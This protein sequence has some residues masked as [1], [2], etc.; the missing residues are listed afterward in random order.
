MLRLRQTQTPAEGSNQQ[1]APGTS[2]SDVSDTIYDSAGRVV[3]VNN[4]YFISN[5]PS[6]TLR[7]P[8][9][10]EASI[11][12]STQTGYDGAG[13][14]TTDRLIGFGT[15]KWATNYAYGGDH[16]DVTPPAGGTLTRTYSDARGRT[17]SLIQYHAGT[18]SGAADTTSY[19]YDPAGNRLS[20]T[21]QAG[22]QWH[23]TYDLFGDALS[24]TDPDTGATT[25]TYDAGQR[26][27]QTQDARGAKLQYGY[28]QLNRKISLQ[29]YQ[30]AGSG[31]WATD[32]VWTY[33]TLAKGQLTS[34][35][36]YVGST[37]TTLGTAYSESVTG[38][39]LMYRPTATSYTLP[40]AAAPLAGTYT[41]SY[42]YNPDGSLA[43]Q[44]DPAEGG[45]PAETISAGYTAIGNPAGATIP[46]NQFAIKYSA[47]GQVSQ[48]VRSDGAKLLWDTYGYDL[49]SARLTADIVTNT[50]GVNFA[51][52]TYAYNNAGS[53]TSITDT[54]TTGAVDTQCFSY[55]Y[56]QRLTQAD[57]PANNNCATAP[58]NTNLGGPAPYWQ[59][60]TYD[61]SGDRQTVIRHAT[62][63]TGSDLR[64]T[65]AYPALGS[66]HR[67]QT[68]TH[69]S[70]PAGTTSYTNTGTA[71]YGY[72][73]AGNTTTSPGQTLSYDPRGDL[74]SVTTSAGTQTNVYD[75]DGELLLRTDPTNGTTAYLG[76]TELTA[77]PGGAV[78]ANRTYQ[79]AGIAYACRTT[80]TG[81]G[82]PTLTWLSAD[83]QGT[84]TIAVDLTTAAA[85]VR[86]NDPFGNPR[87]GSAPAW[88]NTDG[89]LN[90]PTNAFTATT[91]LGA[92]EY[93]PKIGRFL[94]V[95][96][97]LD[98]GD[99]QS[100]NGY[101]YA[102]NDPVNGSD[103]DGLCVKIDSASAPCL[104]STQ[105]AYPTYT[106]NQSSG[107]HNARH[108]AVGGQG[109]GSSCVGSP[110][111]YSKP[112][113]VKQAAHWD[114]GAADRPHRPKVS[115][116]AS[117][118][119]VC[120][121]LVRQAQKG[122][123]Y[124]FNRGDLANASAYTRNATTAVN[125]SYNDQQRAA[126][127][128]ASGV[129]PYGL[130]VVAAVVGVGGGFACVVAEP[131]VEAAPNVVRGGI[132]VGRAIKGVI[133]RGSNK[134]DAKLGK[135][136]VRENTDVVGQQVHVPPTGIWSTLLTT[137]VQVMTRWD[138]VVQ[139]LRRF[140]R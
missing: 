100:L 126:A 27:T 74:G 129:C 9:G 131:C 8:T 125:A 130:C 89:Y 106:N 30:S 65:Y 54:P 96:P 94:S 110:V 140:F 58:T 108:K 56:A 124:Y 102:D 3:T 18:F 112:I 21:D 135:A 23:W 34:S 67:L 73:G 68:V 37:P 39:D 31:G 53:I 45:L 16:V 61:V 70:A 69:A 66:G 121:S 35:T 133:A 76:D 78:T 50:T 48:D 98:T 43:T 85:T 19:T 32:A 84:A 59:T 91:H 113:S 44:S 14:D 95:D 55:D 72:D 52:R 137:T 83:P 17:T 139:Y 75:A 88:P 79:S 138:D 134:V 29:E 7:V 99:P 49:T 82:G 118:D 22:D 41:T 117:G 111:S 105:S 1:A 36:S 123:D 114:G 57:T 5:P 115:S 119:L 13:R 62:T 51:Y 87:D 63:G 120:P 10:G 92:R 11:P 132:A 86:H 6:S 77:N 33:D 101:A 116:C 2:G 42:T 128:A 80:S 4:P 127:E 47:I 136:G 12:S 64:D 46:G 81:G 60:Y 71:T 104:T 38:Y 24:A 26:L 25:N 90:K 93:D 103:A 107:F 28:D 40:A 122:Y 109:C 97:V 15:L 20:M